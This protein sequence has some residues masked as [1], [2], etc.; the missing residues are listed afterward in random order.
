MKKYTG[1]G[2]CLRTRRGGGT[3]R[4]P[5]RWRH[6]LIA[7][8]VRHNFCSEAVTRYTSAGFALVAESVYA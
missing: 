2:R 6:R 8:A 3:A 7:I 5:W 4:A 1:W